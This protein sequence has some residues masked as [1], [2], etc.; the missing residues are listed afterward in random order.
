MTPQ[1]VQISN[2]KD[3]R[4]PVVNKQVTF[5]VQTQMY[6]PVLSFALLPL[7]IAKFRKVIGKSREWGG[8]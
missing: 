7:Q 4:L 3:E 2:P 6:F 5:H 8:G 1:S